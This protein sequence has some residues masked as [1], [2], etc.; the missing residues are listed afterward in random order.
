MSCEIHSSHKML[1]NTL[2]QRSTVARNT[3]VLRDITNIST[4]RTVNPQREK[5]RCFTCCAPGSNAFNTLASAADTSHVCL[6]AVC[7]STLIITAA[8][9]WSSRFRELGILLSSCS[10]DAQETQQQYRTPAKD[11]IQ[12]KG[13]CCSE[14]SVGAIYRRPEG[15][16]YKGNST[17]QWMNRYIRQ[18]PHLLKG[19]LDNLIFADSL[20][21]NRCTVPTAEEVDE[22]WEEVE[23][24][25]DDVIDEEEDEAVDGKEEAEQ[26]RQQT[27]QWTAADEASQAA[28]QALGIDLHQRYKWRELL[29]WGDRVLSNDEVA[30]LEQ[31]S[32][33]LVDSF[34]KQCSVIDEVQD[35]GASRSLMAMLNEAE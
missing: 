8:C 18:H 12:T 25:D 27:G 28:A 26:Q 13:R 23:D 32:D 15:N 5:N 10:G 19:T 9:L 16:Y 33:S 4:T 2:K 20:L 3:G 24:R 22:E 34:V 35:V 17:E 31:S 14:T 6:C 7:L 21:P 1:E 30:A 11:T 29:G